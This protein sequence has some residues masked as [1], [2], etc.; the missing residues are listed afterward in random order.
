M[1]N[2][3]AFPT[4]PEA[5]NERNQGM[6]LL[7]Y[8]AAHA[9]TAL[10]ERHELYVHEELLEDEQ[11]NPANTLDGWDHYLNWTEVAE[12]AYSLAFAM[13]K[14]REDFLCQFENPVSELSNKSITQAK[15]EADVA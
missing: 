2:P 15:S 8:F 14:A 13:I 7:D 9:L 3:S 4:L 5:A 10:I 6:T 11:N 12:G 1:K